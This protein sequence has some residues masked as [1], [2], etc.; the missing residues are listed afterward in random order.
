M[1]EEEGEEENGGEEDGTVGLERGMRWGWD[2]GRGGKWE[3]RGRRE[4]EGMRG[5][6]RKR[7]RGWVKAEGAGGGR[8]EPEGGMEGRMDEGEKRRKS[9]F[10]VSRKETLRGCISRLGAWEDRG[11]DFG[12]REWRLVGRKVVDLRTGNGSWSGEGRVN[13]LGIGEEKRVV[14]KGGGKGMVAGKGLGRS[15]MGFL[16]KGEEERVVVGLGRESKV[17]VL[18]AKSRMGRKG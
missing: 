18:V 6:L 12:D 8:E 7:R 17:L 15:E 2:M 3:G 9:E 11:R 16:D 13:R 4:M 10:G 14:R 5:R 1:R